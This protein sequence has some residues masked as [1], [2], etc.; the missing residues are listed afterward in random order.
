M[1]RH[2]IHELILR[3]STSELRHSHET[4]N[5]VGVKQYGL[6]SVKNDEFFRV[7][8]YGLSSIKKNEVFRVKQYGLSIV[9]KNELGINRQCKRLDRFQVLGWIGTLFTN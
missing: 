5:E 4:E 2:A 6:S 8:Q 7:K 9:D 3:S 1:D